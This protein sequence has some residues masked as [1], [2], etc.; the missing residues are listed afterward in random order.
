[1]NRYCVYEL[2]VVAAVDEEGQE[3]EGLILVVEDGVAGGTQRHNSLGALAGLEA[4][5][6]DVGGVDLSFE[7]VAAA[8]DAGEA[9]DLGLLG[10]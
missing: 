4:A 5:G 3:V 7:S 8:D 9:L 1:M 2:D 6:V 10:G